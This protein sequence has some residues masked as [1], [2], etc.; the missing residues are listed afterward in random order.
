MSAGL[1]ALIVCVLVALLCV[2]FGGFRVATHVARLKKRL[3][4]Y[5]ELPILELAR[6]TQRRVS[7][8]E[9][10]VD[11]VPSLLARA[12]AALE[13]L[14]LARERL[15]VAGKT[16]VATIRALPAIVIDNLPALFAT[17]VRTPES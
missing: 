10:R 6:A 3:G 4:G 11:S 13:E 2:G 17:K 12:D 15:G 1:I 9:R 16:A 8:A 7:A 5:E 14:G